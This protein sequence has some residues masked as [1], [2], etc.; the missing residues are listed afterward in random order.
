MSA[1]LTA[2]PARQW[3]EIGRN[4]QENYSTAILRDGDAFGVRLS[5]QGDST[6]IACKDATVACYLADEWR[7]Q[8]RVWNDIGGPLQRLSLPEPR[9]VRL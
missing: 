2:P 4:E 6:I 8:C 7:V 9:E 5:Y 1:T 3:I